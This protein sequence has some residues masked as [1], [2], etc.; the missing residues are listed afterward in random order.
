MCGKGN[1]YCT[2]CRLEYM[3]RL[4]R[5]CPGS[6]YATPCSRMCKK[7]NN[8]CE[9]CAREY[10]LLANYGINLAEFE[11]MNEAQGGACKICSKTTTKVLR[12]DHNRK[13][14]VVRELLCNPCNLMIGLAQESPETLR[15]GAEYLEKHSRP[16]LMA[17]EVV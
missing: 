12:V 5:P 11:E 7:G 10:R 4:D 6:D 9:A 3:S 1:K 15:S 16:K 2:P 13:T 8:Q 17:V 14:H